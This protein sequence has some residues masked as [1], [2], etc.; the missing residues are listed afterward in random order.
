MSVKEGISR[1]YDR[2]MDISIPRRKSPSGPGSS[3]YQSFTITLRHTTTGRTPLDE[4]SGWRKDLYL[5]THYIHKRKISTPPAGFEPTFPTRERPQNHSLDRAAS[6]IGWDGCIA[7]I[8]CIQVI[9]FWKIHSHSIGQEIFR[10]CVC[11]CVF[12]NRN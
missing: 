4:W 8:S 1:D 10:V 2:K 5:T 11:V 3:H 6:G 9:A 12:I 7:I